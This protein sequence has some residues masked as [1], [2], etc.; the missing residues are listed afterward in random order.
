MDYNVT[1]SGSPKWGLG[2]GNFG[3]SRIS[4]FVQVEELISLA[5]PCSK[6]T[7]GSGVFR[8]I[9]I[10]QFNAF[11]DMVGSYCII[12]CSYLKYGVFV[13]FR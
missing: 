11:L 8:K 10:P 3:N 5:V 9:L 1:R 4:K 7:V 13:G 2:L 12:L 6:D